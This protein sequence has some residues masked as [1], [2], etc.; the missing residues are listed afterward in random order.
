[1]SGMGH[2]V[3]YPIVFCPRCFDWDIQFN[4]M[5]I[6]IHSKLATGHCTLHECMSSIPRSTKARSTSQAAHAQHLTTSTTLGRCPPRWALLLNAL[7]I[8]AASISLLLSLSR[9][10]C[11]LSMIFP[12]CTLKWRTIITL[13]WYFTHTKNVMHWMEL[14]CYP[15]SP[16]SPAARPSNLNCLKGS[17]SCNPHSQQ[18]RMDLAGVNVYVLVCVSCFFSHADII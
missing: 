4:L 13:K 8:L 12:F 7:L 6:I 1:M 5:F 15:D 11:S 3:C 17:P 14:N 9:F 2:F 10:W 16:N 18:Y